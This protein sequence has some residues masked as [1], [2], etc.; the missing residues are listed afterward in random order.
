MNGLDDIEG[1]FIKSVDD[2]K[3]EWTANTAEDRLKEK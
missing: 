3:L 1:M 2:T